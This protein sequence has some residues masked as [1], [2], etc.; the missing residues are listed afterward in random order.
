MLYACFVCGRKK[1]ELPEGGI[2]N[3]M[4]E[5][6]RRGFS[7]MDETKKREI[8]RKGGIAAHRKGTAHKFTSEE[9]REAGRKG[10]RSAHRQGRAHKFTPE[11]ARVAGRKGGMASHSPQEAS[12]PPMASSEQPLPSQESSTQSSSELLPAGTKQE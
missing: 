6:K 5:K 7:A 4:T 3:A 2:G 1:K 10:G 8:A 11:E 9:A 12:Q